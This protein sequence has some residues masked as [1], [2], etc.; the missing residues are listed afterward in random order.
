MFMLYM[1]GQKNLKETFYTNGGRVLNVIST[2]EQTDLKLCKETV[3]K[4]IPE[5]YFDGM[6]YRKDISD[7]ALNIKI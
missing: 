7:K 3:Y 6:Q 4:A 5:I 1:R 2:I